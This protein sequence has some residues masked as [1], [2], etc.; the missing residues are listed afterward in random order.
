MQIIYD[1]MFEPNIAEANLYGNTDILCILA[2]LKTNNLALRCQV[3][4]W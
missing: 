1:D 4:I 2:T 3:F